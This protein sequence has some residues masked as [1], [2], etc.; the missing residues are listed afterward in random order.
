MGATSYLGKA[1]QGVVGLFQGDVSQFKAQ[2]IG[3][4]VCVLWAFGATFVVFKIVN[5]IK[6]MRVSPEVELE[7]L[8]EPEF[9]TLAYPD[10]VYVSGGEG[11][12]PA[13]AVTRPSSVGTPGVVAE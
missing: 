1:G 2:L 3:S 6:S 11:T 4:T 12:A 10:D 7:G 5:A 13:L 8:D 9:G